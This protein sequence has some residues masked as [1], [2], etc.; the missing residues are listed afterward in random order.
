MG[1]HAAHGL[2][3]SDEGFFSSA[4][5]NLA[6]HGFYGTTVLETAET[7]L[8]RLDQRTYWVFPL[9]QVLQAGWMWLGWPDSLFG[10]RLQNEL[11]LAVSLVAM[12][13][14]MRG[15]GFGAFTAA[16]SALLLGSSFQYQDTFKLARPDG[17]CQALGWAG[18]AGYLYW[19]TRRFRWAL[20]MGNA[21]VALSL[22]TH[23]NGV[24]Y[25]ASLLGLVLWLDRSRMSWR[26]VAESAVLQLVLYLPWLLYI[27][28]DPEAFFQQILGNNQDRYSSTWNPVRILWNEIHDRY[29]ASYG[30][31]SR[32]PASALK[33][34]AL[35]AQFGAMGYWL[36]DKD[37][38]SQQGARTLFLLWMIIFTIQLFF[39]QKLMNY[40]IHILPVYCG[41]LAILA[42]SWIQAGQWKRATAVVVVGILTILQTYGIIKKAQQWD[43][44]ASGAEAAHFLEENAGG[45]RRIYGDSC[46]L[47]TL[48]FD[49]RYRHDRYLGLRSKREGDVFV[50][51]DHLLGLHYE[52]LKATDPVLFAKIT[53]RYRD[54]ETVFVRPGCR[55]LFRKRLLP[56]THPDDRSKWRENEFSAV[57]DRLGWR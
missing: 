39:N 30:L 15:L 51:A 49:P 12:H 11:Y 4:A 35:V 25:F 41:F 56:V 50:I 24:L 40:L 48:K 9:F 8:L 38:R 32:S 55:I 6:H 54:Y 29:L 17:L 20:W 46:F 43:W 45:A 52:D 14:L 34:L 10:I 44:A 5:Y 37:R 16:L 53:E 21:G 31:L 36:A 13:L 1:F 42:S 3:S 26:L 28:E 7:K 57:L 19:R 27:A 18:L 23:P 2:P 47:A 22:L 33:G